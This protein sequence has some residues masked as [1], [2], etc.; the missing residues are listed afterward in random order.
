MWEALEVAAADDFVAARQGGLAASV[1][2]EGRNFSGGQRQRL[3][4]ARA[5]LRRP[6]LYVL[7]DPFCALDVDTEQR[8]I[9]NLRLAHPASTI[10]IAAQRVSS[11]RHADVIGVLEDGRLVAVGTDETLR[12]D[13]EI[14][15]EIAHAQAVTNA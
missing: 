9:A 2:Q 8:I 6:S 4:L 5:V 7:D 13:S 1:A 15:R 11:V 12:T 3:A 14:Y 10:L